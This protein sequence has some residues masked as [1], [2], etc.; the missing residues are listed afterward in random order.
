MYYVHLDMRK[1]CLI[2]ELSFQTPLSNLIQ[3]M[4]GPLLVKLSQN[5]KDK[6]SFLQAL[7]FQ[8]QGPYLQN[9][10]RSLVDTQWLERY[11]G[12]KYAENQLTYNGQ[13]LGHFE[14]KLPNFT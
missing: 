13:E 1:A 5:I 4:S 12:C 6:T 3:N 9:L 14:G 8:L 7:L 11:C 10:L 2:R